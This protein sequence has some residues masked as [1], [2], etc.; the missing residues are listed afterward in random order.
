MTAFSAARYQSCAG[1]WTPGNE[2]TN[3]TV[4]ELPQLVSSMPAGDNILITHSGVTIETGQ[5]GSEQYG[6]LVFWTPT[7]MV[8]K[9]W[10]AMRSQFLQDRLDCAVGIAARKHKADWYIQE[11]KRPFGECRLTVYIPHTDREQQ[12]QAAA[13]L[14]R[15]LTGIYISHIFYMANADLA[16]VQPRP[17]VPEAA[18]LTQP[19]FQSPT[20]DQV[21]VEPQTSNAAANHLPNNSGSFRA[22]IASSSSN[23]SGMT[24]AS[25]SSNWSDSSAYRPRQ[26]PSASRSDCARW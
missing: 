11:Y 5:D 1:R 7:A 10:D 9:A 2:K 22:A 21:Y 20:H 12:I 23:S 26:P 24:A 3:C 14:A 25:G 19:V 13:Q 17:C 8:D 18:R 15:L 6:R 16:Q 4:E